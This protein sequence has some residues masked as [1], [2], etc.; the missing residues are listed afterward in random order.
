M[1]VH[2]YVPIG[3]SKKLNATFFTC[4]IVF[5]CPSPTSSL[6]VLV[7]PKPAQGGEDQL[8]RPPL[9]SIPIVCVHMI[10]VTFQF[11]SWMLSIL[12]TMWM[13]LNK[14]SGYNLI[15]A[16]SYYIFKRTQIF[17]LGGEYQFLVAR[18]SFC[19]KSLSIMCRI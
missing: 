7:W 18:G 6:V 12:W 9:H 4:I 10:K 11:E 5:A 19:E 17:I 16:F 2:I 15:F 1:S 14:S 3:N 8:S 13:L